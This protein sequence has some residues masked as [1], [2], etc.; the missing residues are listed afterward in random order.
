MTRDVRLSVNDQPIELDYFVQNFI[1]HTL[2]GILAGLEGVG[3]IKS[4]DISIEGDTVT[5]NLN[6]ALLPINLFVS[7]IIR[8][9]VAGMVSSLKGVADTNKININIKR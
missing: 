7:R 8:N 1:D 9:T 3:E 5:I 2:G 4:M 6:N